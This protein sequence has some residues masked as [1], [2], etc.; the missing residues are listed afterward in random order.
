MS[1]GSKRT[2][3]SNVNDQLREQLLG[4]A[5][6]A[7]DAEEQREIERQLADDPQLRRELEAVQSSLEPLAEACDDVD[8]DPPAGL[9]DRACSYVASEAQR[10]GWQPGSSGVVQPAAGGRATGA[11]TRGVLEWKNRWTLADW[12]V[13]SG[14]CACAVLLFFPAILNSRAMSRM[15]VCQNN[16]RD[17][18]TSLVQYS[19]YVGNGCFPSVATEGNQ[20]FA[21]VFAPRLKDC[22]L[23]IDDRQLVCPDSALAE[24]AEQFRVPTITEIDN[25][26]GPQVWV[27]QRCGGSYA[28]NLG[29]IVQGRH[30][31]IRNLARPTFA[32]MADSP[33]GSWGPVAHGR[34]RNILYE[35][36]HISFVSDQPQVPLAD[37]P[38]CNR[39]NRCEAGIGP[40]DSVVAP[41][42][43][44]PIRDRVVLE[45][46]R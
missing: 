19:E 28:Y 7:L 6:G 36:L 3:V 11:V 34:G 35:D 45:L 38:F 41:S 9:A 31:P 44:P 1:S 12:V 20:S 15:T 32:L 5:L 8:L 22:D 29:V 23:L 10:L 24:Q 4:Y 25:A 13:A 46:T 39:F 21:G 42:D 14:V 2:R 40:N 18:G 16:L 37:D 33:G 26:S 17:L 30:L 27:L 43:C